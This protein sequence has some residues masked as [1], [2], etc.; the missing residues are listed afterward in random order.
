MGGDPP[1]LVHSKIMRSFTGGRSTIQ[2]QRE[3]GG[4]PDICPIYR[5]YEILLKDDKDVREVYCRC[6][7]G[8]LLCGE[9]KLRLSEVVQTFLK[10]HKRKR[11][12]AKKTLEKF[13]VRD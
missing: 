1:E 2:E 8:E 4:I 12:Q 3:K 13:M 5:Y 10:E 9:D 11:E 7:E 6:R